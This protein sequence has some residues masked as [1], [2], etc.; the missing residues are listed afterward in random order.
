M[1]WADLRPLAV[2][3][4]ARDGDHTIAT[5]EQAVREGRAHLWLGDGAAMVTEFEHYPLTKVIRVW[6]GVGD[7]AA[8]LDMQAQ[9][10]AWAKTQGCAKAVIFTRPGW[11]RVLRQRGFERSHVTLTKELT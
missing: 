2:E 6:L 5:L 11:E 10:E 9:V 7:M 1:T 4:L 8:L 3:A